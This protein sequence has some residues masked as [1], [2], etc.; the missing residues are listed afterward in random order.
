MGGTWR[1]SE[2]GAKNEKSLAFRP[3]SSEELGGH[4]FAPGASYW[5]LSTPCRAPSFAPSTGHAHSEEVLSTGY[6]DCCALR[7]APGFFVRDWVLSTECLEPGRP[8]SQIDPEQT[9][10]PFRSGRSTDRFEWL[11]R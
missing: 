2:L 9:V 7:A 11:C 4:Y 5:V 8:P 6:L 3:V 10:R 1:L